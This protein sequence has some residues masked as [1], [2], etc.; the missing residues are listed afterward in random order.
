MAARRTLERKTRQRQELEKYR[1]HDPRPYLRG[2]CGALLK[3]AGGAT[4]DTRSIAPLLP[5][6]TSV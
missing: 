2:R 4:S 6:R 5:W 3:I 1:D